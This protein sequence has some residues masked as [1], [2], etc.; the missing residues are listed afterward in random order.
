LRF[1]VANIG[2]VHRKLPDDLFQKLKSECLV[3]K[4]A[5][6]GEADKERFYSGLSSDHVTAHYY[7]EETKQELNQFTMDMF[8][9]YLHTYPHYI[10]SFKVATRNMMYKNGDPWINIQKK[11]EYIPVHNHDGVVSFVTWVNIPYDIEEELNLEKDKRSV[12]SCLQFHYKNICGVDSS[13]DF[14]VSKQDEG[15]IIMFP[16][17][18]SHTVYPF[19]T[20]DDVRIS[21][22]GCIYFDPEQL[23]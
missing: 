1:D 13:H 8:G 7:V 14:R 6:Y 17:A 9:E 12:N 19:Y 23:A 5:R 21:V 10:S 22:S 3:A 11:G 2:F 15:G 16:S 18:L 20:S 4:A